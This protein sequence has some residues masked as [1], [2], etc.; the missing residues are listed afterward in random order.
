MPERE[1]EGGRDRAQDELLP[2]LA[3]GT[4]DADERAALEGALATDEALRAEHDFV[5]RLRLGVKA[6]SDA[7]DPGELPLRRALNRIAREETRLRRPSGWWRAVAIAAG[8]AVVIQSGVLVRQLYAPARGGPALLG[9]ERPAGERAVLQIVFAPEAREA[10][11]RALLRE[12][13]ATIVDGPSASGVYRVALEDVEPDDAAAI[14][15]AIDRL[16]AR[17]NVVAHVAPE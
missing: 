2:F 12:V 5:A 16:A 14:R 17:R 10:A 11:I 7:P 9:A 3:N 13:Q 8:V 4:L 1:R 6:A 15:G